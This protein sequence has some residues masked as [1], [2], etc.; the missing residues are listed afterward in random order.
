MTFDPALVQALIGLAGAPF[1]VGLTE[2]VKRTFPDL[3]QRWWPSVA[4]LWGLAI[5]F[6][7]A[8]VELYSGMST[9]GPVVVLAVAVILGLMAGLSAGGLY[10]GTR[11]AL[12]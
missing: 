1:I 12:Q 3:E 5:N 7:W 8:L 10:S 4:I 9:Q 11:V 2:W 6:G